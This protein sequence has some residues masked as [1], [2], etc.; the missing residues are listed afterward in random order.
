MDADERIAL[1]EAKVELQGR[2]IHALISMLPADHRTTDPIFDA[3]RRFNLG[4]TALSEPEQKARSAAYKALDP[5][6]APM[7][8]VL[9][10]K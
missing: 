2:F 9:A 8:G 1:L 5:N 6:L 10:L 7:R 3:V 4:S